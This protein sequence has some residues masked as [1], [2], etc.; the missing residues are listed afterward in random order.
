MIGK[1]NEHNK[2]KILE[3]FQLILIMSKLVINQK[4]PKDDKK[5][6]LLDDADVVVPGNSV[7]CDKLGECVKVDDIDEVESAMCMTKRNDNSR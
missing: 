7:E 1:Y 6:P 3:N 5:C 4:L 2:E